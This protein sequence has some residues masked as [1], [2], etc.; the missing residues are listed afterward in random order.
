MVTFQWLILPA[1]LFPSPS[2]FQSTTFECLA[3]IV[4]HSVM[5]VFFKQDCSSSEEDLCIS[6]QDILRFKANQKSVLQQRRKLRE[7]LRQNFND[8]AL[9]DAL[10]FGVVH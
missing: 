8:M 7:K 5:F 9:K 1:E 6:E 2:A 10:N 3:F 4:L